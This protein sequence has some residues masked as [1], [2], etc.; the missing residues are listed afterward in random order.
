VQGADLPVVLAEF[1][2]QVVVVLEPLRVF[3]LLFVAIE[4]GEILVLQPFHLGRVLDFAGVEIP[5]F[6]GNSENVGLF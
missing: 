6:R 4:V 2:P 5:K 3:H 1:G